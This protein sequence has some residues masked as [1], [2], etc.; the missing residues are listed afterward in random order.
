MKTFKKN[1]IGKGTQVENFDIVR[2]S[3]KK[4]ELEKCSHEYEGETYVTFEVA[5]M[6]QP[7]KYG[8]THTCYYQ[9]REEEPDTPKETSSKGKPKKEKAS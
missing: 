4:S 2:I 5:R 7:D 6:Q 9:S 3:V 1:Y 8:K